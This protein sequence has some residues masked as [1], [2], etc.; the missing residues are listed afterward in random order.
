MNSSYAI[1]NNAQIVLKKLRIEEPSRLLI[2]L[3][4]TVYSVL[5]SLNL[6]DSLDHHTANN[7]HSEAETAKWPSSK[8]LCELV[9]CVSTSQNLTDDNLRAIS[10][11]C[12][13][14]SNVPMAKQVD[15]RL[16]EKYLKRVLE[17][18]SQSK[19]T[20]PELVKILNDGLVDLT[21]NTA[22]LNQSQLLVILFSCNFILDL[23]KLNINL[24]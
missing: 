11:R 6:F 1:R 15:P 21:T 10:L 22:Y 9:I 23:D 17:N 20:V 18:N 3:L 13:K 4:N 24:L 19:L 16:Y 2:P 12:L 8:G 5:E 14:L 7:D